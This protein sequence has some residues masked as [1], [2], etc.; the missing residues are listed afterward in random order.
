MQL[1]T[2]MLLATA[3]C[4]LSSV[5]AAAQETNLKVKVPFAFSAGKKALPAGDYEVR[6]DQPT[7]SVRVFNPAT[8]T[9]VAVPFIT[10]LAAP[11]HPAVTGSHIVFDKVGNTYTL[12]EIWW[13]GQDGILV[14]ATKGPHEHHVLHVHHGSPS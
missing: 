12:S 9:E 7:E 3:S 14:H 13:P 5:P 10:R 4:V 11:A 1:R 8:R 6:L 2:A